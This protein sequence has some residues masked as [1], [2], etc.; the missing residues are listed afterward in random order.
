MGRMDSARL[1]GAA[2]YRP[3]GLLQGV[4]V[5]FYVLYF[6]GVVVVGVGLVVVVVVGGG[7]VVVVVVVVV[8]MVVVKVVVVVVVKVEQG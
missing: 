6:V 1:T 3:A 5:V 7:V 2:L 8:V 4:Y